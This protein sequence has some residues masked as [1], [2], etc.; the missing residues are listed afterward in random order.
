[1]YIDDSLEVADFFGEPFDF[2]GF[3][4]IFPPLESFAAFELDLTEK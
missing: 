2:V 1:M 4:F 3:L